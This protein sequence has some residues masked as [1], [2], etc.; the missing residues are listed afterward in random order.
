[1]NTHLSSYTSAHLTKS[2]PKKSMSNQHTGVLGQL[3]L[4]RDSMLK[5]KAV[6]TKAQTF[7]YQWWKGN[8][9]LVTHYHTFS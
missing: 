5:S 7:M 6:S 4:H 9:S 2:S 1:M 8:L 3:R